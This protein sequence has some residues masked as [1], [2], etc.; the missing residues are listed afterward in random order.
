[1]NRFN[2]IEEVYCA[3]YV[4]FDNIFTRLY[5]LDPELAHEFGSNP[6][7]WIRW[8][9]GHAVK[10]LYGE[11]VRRRILKRVCYLNPRRYQEY[12]SYFTMAAFQVV[13]CPPMTRQEKTSTDIHLVMDCLDALHHQ[14][15]FGEFIILSGDSDFTPLLLRLQ[16]Y[17]RKTLVLSVGYTSPAYASAATWRI[18]EDW[19]ITQSLEKEEFPDGVYD[20][21]DVDNQHEMLS[22]EQYNADYHGDMDA[23][24]DGGR[25]GTRGAKS[26]HDRNDR[27]E[28]P[29]RS[30]RSDRSDRADRADSHDRRKHGQRD[31]HRTS[32]GN[33]YS[34]E[35]Q[36]ND[37]QSPSY[38]ERHSR[39]SHSYKKYGH[40][41]SY[42]QDY[43]DDEEESRVTIPVKVISYG[44]AKKVSTGDTDEAHAL[45]DAAVDSLE[46]H[47]LDE[48]EDTVD[49]ADLEAGQGYEAKEDF[50]PNF[51]QDYDE[52]DD[53]DHHS[54]QDHHDQVSHDEEDSENIGNSHAYHDD[55]SIPSFGY[56]SYAST[57]RQHGYA[58]DLDD[59]DDIDDTDDMDDEVNGNVADTI[60][61]DTSSSITPNLDEDVDAG[62]NENHAEDISDTNYELADATH[63]IDLAHDMDGNQNDASQ[64][65]SISEQAA[66][67]LKSVVMES[68]QPVPAANIGQILQRELGAGLDWFGFGK[69]RDF[70]EHIDLTPL[71]FSPVPPGYLYDPSRHDR[72]EERGTNDEFRTKYP[73][74]FTFAL[75]VHRLTDMPLLLPEHYKQ[76]LGYIVEEVNLNGFFMT[77][78]SRNVRDRCIEEGLPIARSHVNF[79]I[80]GVGRGGCPLNDKHG[81]SMRDVAKAFL[82]NA[83]DLCR[84]AQMEL[85]EQESHQ[86]MEW[87]MPKE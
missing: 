24:A 85:G 21:Y 31:Y 3:L 39:S 10:I 58:D 63:S 23:N 36:A 20:D 60:V 59:V 64:K 74:L 51:V 68:S 4:D 26:Y 67:I 76:V 80:V 72:P 79:V 55:H 41:Q 6:K 37:A 27:S 33:S 52:D 84:V 83:Y 57:L 28:R 42:Q 15:H 75:D 66:D 9:E 5:E 14:T 44:D 78:T 54:H 40:D 32:H 86:L 34:D 71:E 61:A 22:M 62:M 1:M 77:T 13:D 43:T 11:G 81:I 18:R 29:D 56:A 8:I 16:E 12:R 38:G 7:R 82:R 65:P 87:I 19:F 30:D 2:G 70:L 45:S 69:L 47:D 53:V 73:E 25:Y 48:H 35:S 46:S 50:A 17:A 49:V